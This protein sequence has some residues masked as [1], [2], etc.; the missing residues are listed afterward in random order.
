MRRFGVSFSSEAYECAVA[1]AKWAGEAAGLWK[2]LSQLLHYPF[3]RRI[4][5]HIAVQNLAS[6]MLDD[7]EAIQHPQRYGRNGKE[8]HGGEDLAVILQK[9]RP[10]PLRVATRVMRPKYRATLRSAIG[11]P[12][13]CSSAWILGPPQ[14]GFSSAIPAIN[15]CSFLEILGRPPRPRER[16]R[17]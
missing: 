13:F 1:L 15:C 7:K 16:Q 11:K 10:L 4:L 3:R 8:I 5:R 2:R 12:S 6:F 14:S 17:Q 9:R